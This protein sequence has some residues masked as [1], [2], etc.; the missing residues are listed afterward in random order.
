MAPSQQPLPSWPST[1][2]RPL[3]SSH[4]RQGGACTPRHS[5]RRHSRRR[6]AAVALRRRPLGTHGSGR[7]CRR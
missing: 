7:R 1:T 6:T 5:S 3:P 2:R 4:R